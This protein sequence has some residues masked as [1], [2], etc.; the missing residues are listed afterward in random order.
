MAHQP[1]DEFPYGAEALTKLPDTSY[2]RRLEV[3][4]VLLEAN[5]QLHE[6]KA[7]TELFEVAEEI[8]ARKLVARTSAAA[9]VNEDAFHRLV[10]MLVWKQN[11]PLT[12][13]SHFPY[14]SPP[15]LAD[16]PWS[17]EYALLS[18]K[19][20]A[21]APAPAPSPA[22]AQPGGKNSVFPGPSARSKGSPVAASVLTSA[23]DTNTARNSPLAET[24][25]PPAPP[26][27]ASPAVASRRQELWDAYCR[28]APQLS[29]QGPWVIPFHWD[30]A[31]HATERAVADSCEFIH[32]NI[33]LQRCPMADP[34]DGVT[35]IVW[36]RDS[37]VDTGNPRNVAD[38]VETYDSLL[39]F[40]VRAELG[41][42][43]LGSMAEHF[44]QECVQSANR[45][46]HRIV[47]N[48]ELYGIR[49]ETED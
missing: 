18:E 45:A 9:R 37:G 43:S 30:V 15:G 21:E 26:A 10:D 48:S 44:R 31:M 32:D 23:Q 42:A 24:P 38:L 17:A 19:I 29:K 49:R 27:A 3:V 8:I 16:K 40:R 22:P 6:A 14:P 2:I 1:T 34:E 7:L 11:A 20:R 12:R 41:E 33:V 36:F 39:D 5:P 46:L 28:T 35:V 25:A 4:H 13:R 47:E